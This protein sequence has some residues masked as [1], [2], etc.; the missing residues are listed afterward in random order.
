MNP[1]ES[2][3]ERAERALD[4]AE[5]V[6]DETRVLAEQAR[7]ETRAA[8]LAWI[9]AVASAAGMIYMTLFPPACAQTQ[10]F[11]TPQA[12]VKKLQPPPPKPIPQHRPRERGTYDR[13]V[14]VRETGKNEFLH[15]RRPM[16]E[17]GAFGE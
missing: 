6:N 13:P 9:I 12:E 8:L 15:I 16:P 1:G 2:R 3:L 11:S 5:K 17:R 7:R 10:G 4:E 14:I